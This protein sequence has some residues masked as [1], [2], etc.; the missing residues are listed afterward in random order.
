MKDQP[1]DDLDL[2]LQI[3]DDDN[4]KKMADAWFS[5]CTKN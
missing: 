2:K 4:F 5:S 3:S 1:G